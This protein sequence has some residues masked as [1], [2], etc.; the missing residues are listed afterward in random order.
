MKSSDSLFADLHRTSVLKVIIGI[1]IGIGLLLLVAYFVNIPATI[2]VL[3]QN[4]ATPKG[5][6][7]AL[8]TGAT[9]LLTWSIRGIRWK[10][11]LNP[12]GKITNLTAI[13]IY[14]VAV[15]LNFLL[16]VRGG[17]IAKCLMLK[18]SA[19]IAVSNSLP[20]VAMDKALDLLPVL[21]IL[22]LVPLL[23]VRMDIKLWMVLILVSL[24]LVGM[25][26]FAALA[27]WKRDAAISLLQKPTGFLS[28]AT[29]SKV[30]VFATG[31][32]DALGMGMRQPKIFVPAIM[33][34]CVAVI[35]D[36]LY[37][38]LAFWTIGY[39]IPFGT[40]IFGYALYNMFY[41]L[42]TL[43][44]QLGSNEAVGL[45][46]WSGLLKLPQIQ[47]TAMLIFTHACTAVLMCAMGFTCLSALGLTISG[48]LKLRSG[49]N[50]TTNEITV[51][52][53]QMERD[54]PSG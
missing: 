28:Q 47:V 31:F 8:L 42:P 25:L 41:I 30:E 49:E 18:R 29:A 52:S 40:A 6:V 35:F 23:G 11:F 51:F 9:Y 45:L 2:Q 27:T 34:T 50:T 53:E 54:P 5:I 21:F 3:R 43:P 7:L 32:V 20:T 10:L 46:V 19:D 14:Q 17:E 4:L 13:Q 22:V 48:V 44:G 38:L 33:L 26:C 12:F 24:I 36:G 16:P 1:L 15:F 39:H 37:I